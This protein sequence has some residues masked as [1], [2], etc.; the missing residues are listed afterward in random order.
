MNRFKLAQAIHDFADALLEEEGEETVI[1]VRNVAA[2]SASRDKTATKEKKPHWRDEALCSKSEPDVTN[3][4]QILQKA[5]GH[6]PF[7]AIDLA[8]KRDL[9]PFKHCSLQRMMLELQKLET[10]KLA[11]PLDNERQKWIL[12]KP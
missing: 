8:Q 6:K 3:V 7:D 12:L 2:R 1:E 5:V 11:V 9:N 10:D 4:Y